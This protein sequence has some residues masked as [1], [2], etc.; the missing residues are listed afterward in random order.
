MASIV[1]VVVLL[2]ANKGVQVLRR[3]NPFVAFVP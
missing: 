1:L 2:E 3:V